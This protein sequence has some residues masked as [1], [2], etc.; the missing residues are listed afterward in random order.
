MKRV[1]FEER[2]YCW[3]IG[4]CMILLCLRNEKVV[5]R[6]LRLDRLVL[7]L[8]YLWHFSDRL[9]ILECLI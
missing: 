8:F 1:I 9:V 3:G 7:S 4:T 2:R 6:G 5:M